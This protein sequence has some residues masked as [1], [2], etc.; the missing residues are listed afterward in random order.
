[1]R[2]SLF[3]SKPTQYLVS[4]DLLSSCFWTRRL[5]LDT[6]AEEREGGAPIGCVGD[7]RQ[8]RVIRTLIALCE[9]LNQT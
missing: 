2:T 4:I 9:S 5:L 8:Q 1:M 3:R 7:D 6:L